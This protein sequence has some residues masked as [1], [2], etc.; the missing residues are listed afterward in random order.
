VQFKNSAPLIGFSYVILKALI[1]SVVPLS[2][3]R[4]KQKNVGRIEKEFTRVHMPNRPK[5]NHYR[6]TSSQPSLQDAH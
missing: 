6:L 4:I 5:H 1:P 2:L 3:L